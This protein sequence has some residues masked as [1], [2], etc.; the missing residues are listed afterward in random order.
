MM[1]RLSDRIFLI[2]FAIALFVPILRLDSQ[3]FSIKEKRK[4]ATFPLLVKNG[5]VN[6][7]YG[8]EFEDWF[9]DRFF[10]RRQIIRLSDKYRYF[11]RRMKIKAR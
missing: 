8:K 3:E 5:T 2:V 11:F 7:A 4:L 9:G 1:N 10:L 6:P